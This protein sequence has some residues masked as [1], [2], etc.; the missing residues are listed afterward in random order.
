[1]AGREGTR[2]RGGGSEPGEMPPL[3]SI[4]QGSL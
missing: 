3:F 2:E 1:M 4:K